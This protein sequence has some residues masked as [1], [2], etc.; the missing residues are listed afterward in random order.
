[1]AHLTINGKAHD[2]EVDPDTPLLWVIREW[3][4]ETAMRAVAILVFVL[5][6][7]YGTNNPAQAQQ[8]CAQCRQQLQACSKNYAGPTCKTEYDICMK[9]CQKK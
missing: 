1:M 9:S 7:S 2:V 8:T 5:V 3:I 6:A 4:G